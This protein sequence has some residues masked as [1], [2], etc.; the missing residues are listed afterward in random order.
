MSFHIQV[1]L[2]I[3]MVTKEEF[4]IKFQIGFAFKVWIHNA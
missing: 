1:V 4:E 3:F 2:L